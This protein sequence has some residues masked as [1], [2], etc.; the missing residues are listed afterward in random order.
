MTDTEFQWAGMNVHLRPHTANG[1]GA[2]IDTS[3]PEQNPLVIKIRAAMTSEADL[4]HLPPLQPLVHGL[5]DRGT[6]VMLFGPSGTGKTFAAIDLAMC[7][8]TGAWW[9]GHKVEPGRVLYIAAESAGDLHP[10]THAWRTLNNLPNVTSSVVFVRTGVNVFDPAQAGALRHIIEADHYDLVILDTL[11]RS[12]IGSEENSNRDAGIVIDQLDKIREVTGATILLVHHT[13]KDAERGMRG[14]SAYYGAA[15]TVIGVLRSDTNG[16]LVTT[17]PSKNGKQRTRSAEWSLNLWATPA[18]QSMAFSTIKPV[19]DTIPDHLL[20]TLDAL[21]AVM[22]PGGVASGVWKVAVGVPEP[23]FYRHRTDLLK[24]G[25]VSQV[26]ESR[27]ARYLLTEQGAQALAVRA[28]L[29]E[30]Y[31]DVNESNASIEEAPPGEGDTSTPVHSHDPLDG[32]D[33]SEQGERPDTLT[34][35]LHS[36]GSHES[37]GNPSSHSH[38]PYRGRECESESWEPA[39]V[40]WDPD[41]YDDSYFADEQ[42][43]A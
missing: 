11:A 38:G 23:T 16:V 29:T 3:D 39:A 12:A 31:R 41:I 10:R 4:K 6:L 8:G 18:G 7:I 24:V 28:G 27:T 42:E 26:G 5:I 13:G 43:P 25:M 1:T 35:S 33:P 2:H 32:I 21:A 40:E 14:A 37:N 15:D 9:H 34:L 19:G 20:D 22:V 36:H 30:M 17:D